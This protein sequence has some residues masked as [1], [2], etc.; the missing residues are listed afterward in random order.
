LVI[1]IAITTNLTV[2]SGVVSSAVPQPFSAALPK[3]WTAENFR[4]SDFITQPQD[5]R[6][7]A[8]TLTNAL[9]NA[10]MIISRLLRRK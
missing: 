9:T 8:L 7:T 10:L 5:T 1:L 6:Q 2:S 4:Y 3:E